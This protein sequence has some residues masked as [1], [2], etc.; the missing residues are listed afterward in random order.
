MPNPSDDD[1][2]ESAFYVRNPRCIVVGVTEAARGEADGRS[3]ILLIQP[4]AALPLLLDPEAVDDI[5]TRLTWAAE[6]VRAERA[7]LCEG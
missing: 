5:V 6:R 1:A 7:A 2:L 3:M 4:H